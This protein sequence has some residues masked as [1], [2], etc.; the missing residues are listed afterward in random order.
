MAT[1]WENFLKNQGEWRG[2][3]TRVSLDGKLLTSTP[4]ILNLEPSADNKRVTFRLRR[5]GPEGY[6]T[7]PTQDYQQDYQSLGRQILF[8][9]TGAFSK[10]SMQLPPFSSFGAEY[11]FVAPDRRLRLVQ[12]YTPQKVFDSLTLIR[13]F[14]SSTTAPERPPL[15]IEQ[16]LGEWQG[17][18][19]TVD[20]NWFDSGPISTHLKIQ[21]IDD[22]HLQQVLSFGD[23]KIA[24]TA[25][26]EGCT[27]RFEGQGTPRQ[28]TLL[29]DG[30]SSNIPLTLKLG[31]PF[32]VEAGW[33]VS[34]RER[35]RLIRHYD[36]KGS[37]TGATHV[38][39]HRV[40]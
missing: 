39:E 14:R 25:R 20:P 26:I 19:R 27:L 7:Q 35:Q 4:S 11:G 38:I 24:S 32:F 12:L 33:L 5:F 1:N 6:D 21:R 9:D 15:T 28:I 29:P 40:S 8:F 17:T 18:A 34:D 23:Q 36:E 2:S 37:W 30:A 31:E 13:E 16:L 3:F 22:S 10:G